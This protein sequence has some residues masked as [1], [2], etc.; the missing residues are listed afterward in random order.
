MV[1][2]VRLAQFL[3]KFIVVTTVLISCTSKK[4]TA[5]VPGIYIRHNSNGLKHQNGFLLYNGKKYSGRTYEL[6]PNA[7]TA[8]L[9]SYVNGKE[10][11]WQ[12]KW[13]NNKKIMEER[14]YIN[15][16]KEGTHKSW[17]QKGSPKFE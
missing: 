14:F 10:E 9:Y 17:W 7:D 4:E 16:R 11:G 15:G 6:Y 3:N 8:V 12:R 1:F 13:Y 5:E 2:M